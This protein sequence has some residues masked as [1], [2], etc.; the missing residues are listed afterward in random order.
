MSV[1]LRI[2]IHTI[3]IKVH[4]FIKQQMFSYRGSNNET[5]KANMN[6]TVNLLEDLERIF[7]Y[8]KN[9]FKE[10]LNLN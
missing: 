7:F 10:V 4:L 9:E 2:V 3:F 8:S 6:L 1:M 5:K